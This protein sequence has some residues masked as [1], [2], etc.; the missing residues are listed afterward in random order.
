MWPTTWTGVTVTSKARMHIPFT[1][2]ICQSIFHTYIQRPWITNDSKFTTPYDRSHL[3]AGSRMNDL[4]RIHQK[5]YIAC[6]QKCASFSHTTL[7]LQTWPTQ[8]HNWS[9][10][11]HGGS[12][13]QL[14]SALRLWRSRHPLVPT[15][16]YTSLC[17]QGLK[18]DTQASNIFPNLS[19][20]TKRLLTLSYSVNLLKK[21][22]ARK[23][24]VAIT[25][26]EVCFGIWI[27]FVSRKLWTL[28]VGFCF[29]MG[30]NN[31]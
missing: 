12:G 6:T 23:V 3:K 28:P 2:A 17:R 26:Q 8:A 29:R 14:W 16:M 7:T 5:F 9:Y 31:W 22:N 1:L 18:W 30:K 25:K 4:W 13:R 19:P 11:I 15:G 27:K 20:E 24:I 21:I 10:T